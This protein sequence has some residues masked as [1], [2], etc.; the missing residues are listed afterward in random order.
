MERVFVGVDQATRL[1]TGDIG[2]SSVRQQAF[3]ER[4]RWEL[5]DE[6]TDYLLLST[7]MHGYSVFMKSSR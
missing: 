3:R 5:F 1:R 4:K 7:L 2:E 6:L